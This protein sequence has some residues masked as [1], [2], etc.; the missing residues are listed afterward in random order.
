MAVLSHISQLY[1]SIV[2]LFHGS[3]VGPKMDDRVL[4]HLVAKYDYCGRRR[5][6]HAAEK[7]WQVSNTETET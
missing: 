6:R 5:R 4:A 1:C 3:S 7:Y 2:P